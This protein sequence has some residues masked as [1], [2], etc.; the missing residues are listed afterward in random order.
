MR[1]HKGSWVIMRDWREKEPFIRRTDRRIIA[2][3][4]S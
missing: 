4:T 1:S 2:I 3:V